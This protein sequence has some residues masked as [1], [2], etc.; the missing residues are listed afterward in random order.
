MAS[1][2]AYQPSEQPRRR[3]GQNTNRRRIAQRI[4][5]IVLA[6]LPNVAAQSEA[7]TTEEAMRMLACRSASAL[8]R[9]LEDL[10]VRAYRPGKY[11]RNDIINAVARR[12]HRA[13]QAAKRN[14]TRK[15]E[16]A[17]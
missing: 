16:V 13:Q 10:G 1:A 5:Q 11:R 15:Q 12:S 17:A 2:R 4:A 7:V 9:E 3:S 6:R 14:A 8:Y